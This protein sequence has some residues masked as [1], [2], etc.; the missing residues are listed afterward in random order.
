MHKM[1]DI[2]NAILSSGLE[3]KEFDEYNLDMATNL[4][5]KITDK[6]PLSYSMV[7]KKR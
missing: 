4:N 1:G 6:I 5:E 3:I 2:I 7:V